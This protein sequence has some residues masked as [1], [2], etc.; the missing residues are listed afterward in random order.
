MP[1]ESGKICR[2]NYKCVKDELGI[3]KGSKVSKHGRLRMKLKLKSKNND[4]MFGESSIADEEAKKEI[5]R[6]TS[7]RLG[8]SFYL[9]GAK[10]KGGGLDIV[11]N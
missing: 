11:L 6:W 9:S 3:G 4:K 2:G 1:Y 10:L 5:W 8:P 7:C